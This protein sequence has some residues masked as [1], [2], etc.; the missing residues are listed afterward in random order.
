MR[1]MK[2]TKQDF[3]ALGNWRNREQTLLKV[4]RLV[5]KGRPRTFNLNAQQLALFLL[6]QLKY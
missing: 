4:H 1:L 5:R 6:A 2:L 3:T